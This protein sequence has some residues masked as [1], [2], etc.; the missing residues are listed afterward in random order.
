MVSPGHH[1]H[2]RTSVWWFWRGRVLEKR[3]RREEKR[4]EKSKAEERR[5]KRGSRL[6]K[7]RMQVEGGWI[8]RLI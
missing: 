7:N 2:I 6:K 4:F 1:Y 5:R 8:K 3:R